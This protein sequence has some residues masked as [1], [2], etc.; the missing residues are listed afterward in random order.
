MPWLWYQLACLML[1]EIP[2]H[3]YI[4]TC[5]S[6]REKVSLW[7]QTQNHVFLYKWS[8]KFN[9]VDQWVASNLLWMLTGTVN[10]PIN[11][12][13]QFTRH[14]HIHM[15]MGDSA[16]WRQKLNQMESRGLQLSSGYWLISCNFP[17]DPFKP[18][19]N[20]SVR[21]HLI[22]KGSCLNTL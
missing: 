12:N 5:N 7:R 6:P 13:L 2:D 4:G 19:L 11:I 10:V 21:D 8:W 14:F 17:N 15:P 20:H 1:G 18:G 22:L 9:G 3:T 16:Y